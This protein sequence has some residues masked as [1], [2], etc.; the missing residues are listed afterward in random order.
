[1]L[2]RHVGRIASPFLLLAAVATATTALGYVRLLGEQGTPVGQSSRTLWVLAVIVVAAAS[3]VIG[4]FTRA[5][6]WRATTAGVVA[7]LLLPLG[8]IAAFSIGTP[9]LLGG[10]FAVLG[11]AGGIRED[12]SRPAKTRSAVACVVAI[13]VL[14]AGFILTP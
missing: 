3:A 11:W 6:G 5:A 2:T 12:P 7:G 1:M 9:L 13:A 4:A 8:L 10:V 14:I